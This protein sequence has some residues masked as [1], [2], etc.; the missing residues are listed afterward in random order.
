MFS[1][2]SSSKGTGML[3][4]SAGSSRFTVCVTQTQPAGL[5]K[6]AVSYTFNRCPKPG[7]RLGNF[8]APESRSKTGLYCSHPAPDNATASVQPRENHQETCYKTEPIG[9]ASCN[10]VAFVARVLGASGR[11]NAWFWFHGATSQG[12]P[13]AE[14]QQSRLRP[15]P[16]GS[17]ALLPVRVLRDH[18]GNAGR[19]A[20]NGHHDLEMRKR[21]HG[22]CASPLQHSSRSAG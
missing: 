10:M 1:A 15:D 4:A 12:E 5:L 16:L 6:P 21:A 8:P 9:F 18:P 19:R 11:V 22:R 20:A 2:F 3:K 14:N 17:R 13:G 7:Y